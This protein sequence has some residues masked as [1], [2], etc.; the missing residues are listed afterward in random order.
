[1]ALTNKLSNIATAIREKTGT[2]EL[3]TLDEMPEKIAGIQGGGSGGECT[4]HHIPDEALVLSGDCSYRF[5]YDGWNW[6]IEQYGENIVTE[7]ISN[8]TYMFMS[9][10]LKTIPFVINIKQDE[11][12]SMRIS[13]MFKDAKI[14]N[15][16]VI[17]TNGTILDISYILN[18]C[19][20][21]RDANGL[22]QDEELY[23]ERLQ[24]YAI[25]N[26]YA[27]SLG[28]IFNGCNSLRSVPSWYLSLKINPESTKYLIANYSIY[29]NVFTYCYALDE[30]KGVPVWKC[31]G[32]QTGNMFSLTFSNCSRAKDITFEVDNDGSPIK[33]EWKTQ[34]ID[35]TNYIGYSYSTS[36][37][38]SAYKHG[39]TAETRVTDDA[40]YQA[41]KDNPDLWTTNIAYSR[42]NHDSA[43]RTIASLP[44]TS[45]YL[46]S[47]GGTNT[48]KFKGDAGSATDGGAI[49]TLTPEEISIAAAK[50]WTVTL[51]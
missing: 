9:C 17:K 43:V 44:D 14:E 49:N 33:T 13:N 3:M 29:Y 25:T 39:I 40:S 37:F 35:L 12:Y 1:M 45:A 24:N 31:K 42:Y 36:Y 32:T 11:K 51:V 22:F 38:T 48:I 47:A 19:K 4:K 28:S 34:T 5:S 41:L 50:G 10:S 7:D 16:P 18:G 26:N 2:T 15:V 27:F 20:Y 23:I 30:I 8:G 21:L 46:A 6:F